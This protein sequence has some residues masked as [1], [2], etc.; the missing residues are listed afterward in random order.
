YAEFRDETRALA[1]GFHALGVRK[2][3]KVAL[4]QGNDVEWLLVDFAVTLL[5]GVLVAMNTWWRQ[6]EI[7]HGLKITDA[8]VLVMVGRYLNN[9]YTGAL[10][11]IGDLSRE[12]PLLK[13]IV[14]TGGDLPPGAMPFEKLYELGRDI[15]DAVIDGAQNDVRPED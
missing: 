4:L 3:D 12:L 10:R 6:R 13:T 7:H 2:G 14:G 9:D 8:S 11:E 1:K 5:G 15:P